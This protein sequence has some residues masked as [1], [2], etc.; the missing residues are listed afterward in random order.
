M[1]PENDHFIPGLSGSRSRRVV[2]HAGGAILPALGAFAL[3]RGVIAQATPTAA[4]LG[5][6]ALLVQS[7]SRGSLFPTQGDVGVAPYTVILWDSAD[8]GFFFANWA[9]GAAGVTPTERVLN[10]IGG[11]PGPLRAVLTAA[12]AE[13][14]G[15]TASGEQ[16]WALNLVSGSVGSDPGAVTY[17]GESLTD[18]DALALL[19]S[20]PADLPDGPRDLGSGFLILA[21]L[22]AFDPG[23]GD[24]VRL[25]MT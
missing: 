24:G 16:V 10:A 22:S 20:A 8:R 7:F 25:A 2:L 1:S 18:E 23:D 6:R 21:G 11:E 3:P 19:G 14:S 12:P 13:A 5:N 4:G 9:S 15:A 17:Q